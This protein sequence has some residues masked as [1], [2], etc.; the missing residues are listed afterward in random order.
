M[1]HQRKQIVNGGGVGEETYMCV[2][3]QNI[4]SIRNGKVDLGKKWDLISPECSQLFFYTNEKPKKVKKRSWTENTRGKKILTECQRTRGGLYVNDNFGF[5]N[6]NGH[7]GGECRMILATKNKTKGRG[8]NLPK[9]YHHRCTPPQD[10]V[11]VRKGGTGKLW[12][13]T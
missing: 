10:G 12:E 11:V 9:G 13:D 2:G 3:G 5:D 4:I 6:C 8:G 1:I 7:G